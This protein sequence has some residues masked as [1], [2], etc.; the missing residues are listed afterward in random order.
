[1]E[2]IGTGFV[3][4]IGG[5]RLRVRIA[6]EDTPD[7]C[8]RPRAAVPENEWDAAPQQPQ[9]PPRLRRSDNASSMN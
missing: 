9:Q 8:P 3:L 5:V 6:L 7:P 1:M 2:W 4:T